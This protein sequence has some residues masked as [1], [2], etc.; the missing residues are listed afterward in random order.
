MPTGRDGV[1]E[2]SGEGQ[3]PGFGTVTPR[4]RAWQ[5]RFQD[6]YSIQANLLMLILCPSPRA[7]V[8]SEANLHRK[9]R[10]W[11]NWAGQKVWVQ[12]LRAGKVKG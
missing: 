3:G 2:E 4:L 9:P 7:S 8:N 12:L 6:S 11:R 5:S 10:V 1:M